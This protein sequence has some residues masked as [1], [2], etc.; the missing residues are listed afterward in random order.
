VQVK[1]DQF[2]ALCYRAW[3]ME[4]RGDIIALHLTD[5]SYAELEREVLADGA[6]P[7]FRLFIEKREAPG[8]YRTPPL[9]CLQNPVTRSPVEVTGGAA[10][11]TAEVHSGRWSE[12]RTFALTGIAV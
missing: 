2:N 1:L 7:G 8:A 4:S 12:S 5:A 11:D 6:L 9:A 10:R 3:A